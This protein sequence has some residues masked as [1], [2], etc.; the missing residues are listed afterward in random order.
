VKWLQGL[1]LRATLRPVSE[2][3]ERVIQRIRDEMARKHLSQLE[4]AGL[5][6]WT[7][8][9]VTQKLN[10][11]S[12]TTLDEL[13]ALC[14]AVGMSVVEVVRDPGLEFV[15]DMTP[16]EMRIVQRMR[17]LAPPVIQAILTILRLNETTEVET[18]YAKK[19]KPILAPLKP[20]LKARDR[21]E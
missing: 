12:P 19:P 20:R 10:H 16:S 6:Q 13:E 8:S 4:V 15:A 7:Q 1:E 5:L 18:R 9:R 14:F 2:F 17:Q 21:A 11:R 3:S